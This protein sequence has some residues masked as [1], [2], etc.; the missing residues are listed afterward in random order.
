MA[1]AAGK[2]ARSWFVI[3]IGDRKRY[4]P[5]R[6]TRRLLIALFLCLA[7][8]IVVAAACGS[9]L[10]N[11]QYVKLNDKLSGEL[12]LTKQKLDLVSQERDG[13]AVEVGL[14]KAR[15]EVNN[16]KKDTP[17]T[18]DKKKDPAVSPEKEMVSDAIPFVS[19]E[20]VKI[21]HDRET[22]TMKVRCIIKNDCS[23]KGYISGYV[24]I[25]L[26]P[27]V[28]SSAERKTSP[29]VTL[30]SGLPVSY[31][32]GENFSIARF[33]HIEG[34]FHSILEKSDY[35]SASF[36]VYDDGGKLRLKKD[37]PL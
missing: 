24:F 17:L 20:A 26:N 8:M 14:L 2:K 5:L 15:V 21:S 36:L 37:F 30:A 3:I 29:V 4:G 35:A 18:A 11:R 23:S 10:Y 13:F 9:L 28:G 27:A 33:K 16:A 12:N 31:K 25:I 6:V 1:M 19:V 32:K 7:A 34:R 22:K